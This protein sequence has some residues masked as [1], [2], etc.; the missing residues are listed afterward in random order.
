MLPQQLQ[1]TFLNLNDWKYT[2]Y[3]PKAKIYTTSTSANSALRSHQ[4]ILIQRL[5]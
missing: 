2:F 1:K 4:H 5:L 3:T